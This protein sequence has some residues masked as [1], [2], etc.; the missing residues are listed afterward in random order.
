MGAELP[1]PYRVKGVFERG[2]AEGTEN[3][4]EHPPHET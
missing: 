2:Q 1:K 3:P 4:T